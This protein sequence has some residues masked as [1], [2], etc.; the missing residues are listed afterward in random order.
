MTPT[1][2]PPRKAVRISVP[3]IN[4]FGAWVAWYQHEGERPFLVEV[5]GPDPIIVKGE[6]N[7]E[8]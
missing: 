1:A 7:E 8:C 5:T 3:F 2:V 4:A 6:S